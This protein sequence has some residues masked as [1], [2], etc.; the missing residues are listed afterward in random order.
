VSEA[1]GPEA[2][3][4]KIGRPPHQPT[5]HSQELVR[6]LAG[7]GFGEIDIARKVGVG[8]TTLRR[9]YGDELCN[10]PTDANALIAKKLF[11][12]A[13]AGDPQLLI[14]WTKARMKWKERKLI[15][16]TPADLDRLIEEYEAK[17]LARRGDDDE[18]TLTIDGEVEQVE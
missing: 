10:G 6:T 2:T 17:L 8:R 11:D 14:W 18:K 12:L 9:H 5:P 16:I 7:L 4:T 13:I 15:E 3:N 1:A